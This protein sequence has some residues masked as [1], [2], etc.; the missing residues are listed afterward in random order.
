M[1][2]FPKMKKAYI[3]AMVFAA[4]EFCSAQRPDTLYISATNRFQVFSNVVT[5]PG[6]KY[7][8]QASG[9]ISYWRPDMPADTADADA[10][11]VFHMPYIAGIAAADIDRVNLNI[12]KFQYL[13]CD[14]TSCDPVP[15]EFG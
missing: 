1:T 12:G 10:G 7:V 8:I 2:G 5:V 4:A 15:V 14:A 3:L 6:T 9:R 11:F 13:P